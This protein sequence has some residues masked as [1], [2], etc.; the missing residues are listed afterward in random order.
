MPRNRS[1]SHGPPKAATQAAGHDLGGPRRAVAADRAD[2]QGVLAQEAHRPPRRQLAEDAQRDH[3]PDAE[4]LPVGPAARAVRPQEHGPR[5]VPALGRGGHLREDLGGAG[6]RVRR[7]RRGAVAVASRPTR[8]WARPGSGG[9]KTGKNPTDRGKKGTKK[10]LL[11]DGDGGPLGV[12]IAGA[13][14][15]EQKLLEG[16]D[17]GDR[18]RAARPGGGGAE[19]VPGQGV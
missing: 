19:P 2:P 1:R 14:V 10:S 11:T 13:N 6:R 15:V 7:T 5:L 3:L 9:K 16:D 18:G 8:C 4:R 12:V 17:R